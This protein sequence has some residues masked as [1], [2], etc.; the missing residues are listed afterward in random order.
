MRIVA[1]DKC[2]TMGAVLMPALIE[3]FAARQ[4]YTVNREDGEG[5]R[6]ALLLSRQD[7]GKLAARFD[8]RA[9]NGRPAEVSSGSKPGCADSGGESQLRVARKPF[10]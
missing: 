3:A 2:A 9:T 7:D 8:F 6:F 10:P 1:V 4:G 5:G